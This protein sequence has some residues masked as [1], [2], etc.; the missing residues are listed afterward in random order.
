MK[1]SVVF[2]MIAALLLA[3][4]AAQAP[5][6]VDTPAA[7][8]PDLD[9]IVQQSVDEAMARYEEEQK[10][11]DAEIEK[12]KEQLE[13]L[14]AQAEEGASETASEETEEP[15]E[16]APAEGTVPES[17]LVP[18]AETPTE[19]DPEPLPPSDPVPPKSAPSSSGQGFDLKN[20]YPS[21]V[22]DEAYQEEEVFSLEEN[23]EEE[24][25]EKMPSGEALE[26]D[27]LEVIRLT[28]I[29]RESHGLE[30]LE[31]DDDLMALAQVR[32]EEVSV[33]YSHERPDGT[34]VV[35]EHP[36]FGE[37][38]GAKATAEKQVTSWM[39]SEGHCAN[40]LRERFHHIGVGCYRAANGNHYWVQVFA[41]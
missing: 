3:G 31:M 2:L 15:P 6:P 7:G 25:E 41:P 37:N 34:R 28:N 10:A 35:K 29:Q 14:T 39:N 40:I 4:C 13:A 9:A 19:P 8:S 21:F 24:P 38:V 36:G 12:L 26:N 17:E 32:A 18:P 20:L 27:A 22:F 33:K 30:P 23:F 5:V 16:S 11:K 1:K